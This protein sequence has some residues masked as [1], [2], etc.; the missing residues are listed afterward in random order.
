MISLRR[1]RGEGDRL[2]LGSVLNYHAV[3][4]SKWRRYRAERRAAR[5]GCPCKRL[6]D[7]DGSH[8]GVPPIER[9]GGVDQN[10]PLLRR[11]VSKYRHI[12]APSLLESS[13]EKSS[14][15]Q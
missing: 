3:E 9:E 2:V 10:G 7:R 5:A 8:L 6:S 15:L 1:S 4:A 12:P 11:E 14:E 13:E